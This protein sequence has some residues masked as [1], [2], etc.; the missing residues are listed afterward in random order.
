LARDVVFFEHTF[1]SQRCSVSQCMQ[2]ILP[3]V[4]STPTWMKEFLESP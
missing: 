3:V 1:P 2:P 4:S